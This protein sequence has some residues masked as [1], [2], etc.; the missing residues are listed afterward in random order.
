MSALWE[1]K[2]SRRVYGLGHLP[3]AEANLGTWAMK[4]AGE[5]EGA[6]R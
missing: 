1:N 2:F 5:E 4:G 3:P 6:M